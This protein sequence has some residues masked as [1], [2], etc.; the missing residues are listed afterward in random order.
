MFRVIQEQTASNK[1]NS[2]ISHAEAITYNLLT[3][4]QKDDYLLNTYRAKGQDEAANNL[5]ALADAIKEF[6]MFAVSS[7]TI[8]LH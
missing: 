2:T 4:A 8:L 6:G 3:L 1:F 7:Y 5:I